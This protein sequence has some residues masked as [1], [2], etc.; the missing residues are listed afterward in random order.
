MSTKPVIGILGA[1]R[2]GPVLA[3]L[4]TQ[5]GYEV[6]IAASGD[7]KRIAS[8]IEQFAKGAIATTVKDATA[9]AEVVI[10]ALPLGKYQSLDVD[11]LAGKLVIDAMN[12]WWT[13]DG[14]RKEFTNPLISSSEIVR[15]FLPAS[16]VVKAFNHMGYEELEEQALPAGAPDRKAIGVAGDDSADVARVARIVDDFGF[17]PLI[18]GD[19]AEGMKLEPD[20]EAFGADATVD[21]LRA[22]VER[23]P[24]SQRGRRVARALEQQASEGQRASDF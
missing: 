4:G 5:A 6:L 19:L 21:E 10:L 16:R 14:N 17:D 1:G 20:T 24:K 12:Y 7:P 2:L 15:D 23:F 18:I 8:G 13:T 3:K 9:R 22:M 11:S